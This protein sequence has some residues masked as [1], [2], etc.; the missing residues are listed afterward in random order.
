MFASSFNNYRPDTKH[1]RG[2]LSSLSSVSSSNSIADFNTGDLLPDLW[3]I[4]SNESVGSDSLDYPFTFSK[5]TQPTSPCYQTQRLELFS[6]V[7]PLHNYTQRTTPLWQHPS[8]TWT[9]QPTETQFH[10]DEP[11]DKHVYLLD[12]DNTTSKQ[13]TIKSP[14][15]KES[16]KAKSVNTQLYKTELCGPFMKTGT[17]PYGIKCQFAH[18]ESE[19]KHIERPPKWRSKPCANW[20]KY[21]S[22]RLSTLNSIEQNLENIAKSELQTVAHILLRTYNFYQD[23]DSR[24]AVLAAL[25]SISKIDGRFLSYYVEFIAKET[26]GTTLAVTDYLTLLQWINTFNIELA[27]GKSLNERCA[28]LQAKLFVKCTEDKS[29]KHLDRVAK[30]AITATKTSIANTL[31]EDDTYMNLIIDQECFALFGVLNLAAIELIPKK[32][33]VLE[34]FK[35]HDA[36]VLNTFIN[37]V[38]LGKKPTKFEVEQFGPCVET[39]VNENNFTTLLLPSIEKAIL[40]SSENS[41]GVVLPDLFKHLQIEITPSPKLVSSIISG[42]KSQKENVRVGAF[43][44]LDLVVAKSKDD[45]SDEII[46]AIKTTTNAESKSLLIKSLISTADSE[47]VVNSLLPL[48]AKEQN[49]VSLGSLVD[50]FA[51]HAFKANKFNDDVIKAFTTGFRSKFKRVWYVDYGKHALGKE[52]PDFTVVFDETLS[53][54]EKA[55]AANIKNIACAFVI[56]A[57]THKDSALLEETKLFEKLDA[58]DLYWFVKDL[59]NHP[60]GWLYVLSGRKVP[61]SVKRVAQD[62]F[63]E[64]VEVNLSLSDG[65]IKEAYELDREIHNPRDLNAV[66]SIL[67]QLKEADQVKSNA[68]KLIIAANDPS[69]RINGGWIGLVQRSG[70]KIDIGTL[71]KDNYQKIFTEC[72]A[73]QS[74]NSIKALATI[75]FV[76]PES[77]GIITKFI[78]ESLTVEHIDEV[79]KSIYYGK[80]GEMVINVIEKKPKALDKNAKDYEIRAW[81]ESIGKELKQAKKLTP[82]EKKLVAEQIAKESKI[83]SEIK[84]TVAKVNFAIGLIDELAAQAKVVNNGADSWFPTSV[85][86]LLDLAI[87]EGDFFKSAPSFINLSSLV[88]SRFEILKTFVGVAILRLYGV[89]VDPKYEEEPLESL[90]GRILYRV[91]ILSDQNPLDG[92]SLAY[93]LPLLIKVLQ[94]G[95]SAAFKNSKKIAVTSEFVENDPEEEH[96]LLSVEIIS[97]HAELFAD[98]GIPRTSILQILV[99][100]MAVPSKAKLVKEC[101]LSLC[102]YIA[103][104]ISDEDLQLLLENVVSPHVFVR[105]TILEG[106]DSEFELSAYSKEV[107]VETYDTDNNCRELAQTIW[108]DNSLS[109]PDTTNLLELFELKDAGLRLSVAQAYRDASIQTGINLDELFNFYI[110]KK[111]PPAPKLDE[112]GLVIKSTIDQRDRW[113]ERSTI[114]LALKFLVPQLSD[115]DIEKLFKFLVDE[116]LGDKDQNV[117]Q[118]YQDAGVAAIEIH[119][120][121]NVEALIRIFEECLQG[122]NIKEPV[123]VLY[124]TLARHLK[125]TDERLRVI[126][127]RL[128]KSLDTPNVQFAVSE[129]IAPLV[130]SFKD[131]LPKYFDTLF[132]TLFTG[133]TLAKRRGAAF[134][135]AGLVKGDGV[136]AL[137]DYDVIRT[138]TD[139]SDDKKDAVKRESVSLVFESLSKS[140]GKF[141]EPFVFEILPIILKS[142][143]D[144]SSEVRVA[145]D[146]A[147]K[148]IMKNT[149]SFGVKKLIPL[150]ISNLDEIAWR[151]KKGSV[152]LLGA[153]AYLDPEQLSASLSIIIPEIVG[154][155]NDTHKEVRKAAEQSLKRFGEVIRNPEIQ[156]IV[157]YLINAIGDPTK[158]LDEALD[159]LTKTQFVHYIDS[160]SLALIIHVIHRAMKDR[161]ASTKKKACQIVG[162][163]A[164]L[165]DSKDLQPYLNELVEELET[166]MVDP[167]P[168]T[169]STAARALGSLVEKLGEEQFPGLISK[170]IGTLQDESKAGDRLGSAQALSEVICGLGTNKLEEL[171]P[172]IISSASSPRSAVRAGFMPLLL[173]LPVCFGSQFAPYLNR[174]IPPILNGLADQD[175]EIR[176]TALRAGRLIVKNYA[177]KAVDLLLP[178]LEAG[179]SNESYRIRLSSLELT[180]DLLF[181]IT[182]LSGKNELIEDQMVN[183]T[184]AQVL[185]QERR[186]RILAALFVCRS[187]V[188][189]MVRNASADIWKALVANTPRTVKEIL[190]TLTSLIVQK[191][192]SDDETQRTIAA[193]TLGDMVRRVGANALPQLLP[194]LKDAKDQEGACIAL[195]EL[196]KSTSLEGLTTYRDTFVSIIYNGLITQDK[197]TRNAA[198]QAFEQLYEQIGKVVIDEII[199]Q[200]LSELSN[201]SASLMALKE[202]MASKS[203]IIFPIT[204][205]SLLEPPVDAV[206]LASLASVAGTALYKRLSTI[207]NTL[208][209]SIIAGEEIS[210]EFNQVLLSVEDDGAHLLMQQLLALM[211]HEDPQI[212]E[213]I[214]TQ[215]KDF[216]EHATLD[217]SMYLEDI[218]YQMILSLADPSPKV[219]KASMESLTVLIKKQPKELLE[220]LVK[221]SYQALRLTGVSVPAFALP[222]GPNCI[223]P[224]FLHGLMYGSS[225]QRELS[226]LAIADII[227]KTPAENLRTLATS[228]TGPLIR[229]IGE[230]VA[231]NIKSAILVALNNLLIKIPQFLRPFIPQLQRTFVRSLS[232]VS[233]DTLRKRAVV[234]LSTLI[235]HQPRVDSL[236]T[237]LVTNSKATDDSGV[238]ASMLQG[239]LAVVELKG[240]ELNEASKTSLLSVVEEESIDSVSSAKL[241]GSL[242]NV[243]TTEETSV[244]LQKKVVNSQSKFSIL[245]INAFLKYAPEL[246]KHNPEVVDFVAACSDST[247]PYISDNATI[248]IGKLVL[249]EISDEA[250]Y[251]QLAKNAIQPNSASPDTRRLSLIVIRTAAHKKAIPQ[252]YLDF[253]VPS[254]F[255]SVRDPI[256]P[257]KL[258]AEKA[259]LEVFAIVDQELKVFDNWFNG[260]TEITT[261]TGTSIVP[262]SIGDYTKRVAVRLAHVERERIEQGGDEETLFSDRI[263]DEKEI[264]SVGI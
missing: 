202:L 154:V 226:A 264:W 48:V 216:F 250:L 162:N 56:L 212:R 236:I 88:T 209:A 145:T 129:C 232:D 211:K 52:Q 114:A 260:R 227:E 111:N 90:L 244:L 170:L 177:K 72:V 176:E 74:P 107:Y 166:A 135:I 86:K 196:I 182:G 25:I 14:S 92:V 198:A 10:I 95:Q 179:L 130:P 108:E 144:M 190:P 160:S 134:G 115:S 9:V 84:S 81:E 251:R 116:A 35:S 208:I 17:C 83:R 213:V 157:P 201:S 199:P 11:C 253:I 117:R 136:R 252:E 47:K 255:S 158:H 38:L 143:G 118:Q 210:E 6:D 60:K 257:I 44:T 140:L 113:E 23:T 122:K 146:N 224:V 239:M 36:K 98:A 238:K 148:E 4:S 125:P 28:T 234:A 112:Y 123:V 3:Q 219:V 65:I 50:V 168:A 247:I 15:H 156:Q 126:F 131:E 200:L 188:A 100:L 173:F 42:V 59:Y 37:L 70:H 62:R 191:L 103:V 71:V 220:K 33:S 29:S 261:V 32:P 127:D 13:T 218:V 27:R 110:E 172:S 41:F 91:K 82:E 223:L 142:L 45:I 185:G 7:S 178:E 259:Y 12:D 194:S 155:L 174:I 79:S 222:K 203:E 181:Q 97:A 51:Y 22:C 109:V 49:E 87:S 34:K 152:E 197:P 228:L 167:V 240:K 43:H 2:A 189:G 68:V 151:S 258:A 67:T 18:G 121:K 246:V 75:A 262:R 57:L 5:Q 138:L 106:L 221:P 93:V 263:E 161:S 214:F 231:S 204:L 256:I 105:S 141:F 225:D 243:L 205:P 80:E 183:K 254:V 184:L 171:L 139:A 242:A 53:E 217:Y 233:N 69:I 20:A 24:N 206:A 66:F 180:G 30:S 193:Q 215:T 55:P 241:L 175:E 132:D 159:R 150:A 58:T 237:E 249:S 229:V 31:L 137:S 94:I 104:N 63:K 163:M 1:T 40:R 192:A 102:Q 101:F 248:A 169:R 73:H 147:A 54:I 165:V 8:S 164:I 19:L 230:K 128:M 21:G 16:P 78:E 77:V 46:K 195:T 61:Y 39:L 120:A 245:A 89:K 76:Q 99:S 133:K 124:G 235:K 85:K 207:L 149:T 186:D 153:M 119:G 64:E 187:D 26:S 96:L